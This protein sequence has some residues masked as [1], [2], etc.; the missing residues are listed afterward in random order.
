MRHHGRHR[1]QVARY[2][3]TFVRD[4][5]V[6]VSLVYILFVIAPIFI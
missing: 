4:G 2:G 5:L 1:R 3:D 6:A